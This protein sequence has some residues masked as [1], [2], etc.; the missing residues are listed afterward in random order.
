MTTRYVLH[1]LFHLV[2]LSRALS[3]LRSLLQQPPSPRPLP[4]EPRV[5]P[6]APSGRRHPLPHTPPPPVDQAVPSSPPLHRSFQQED[7]YL[8]SAHFLRALLRS[9]RAPPALLPALAHLNRLLQTF[10]LPPAMLLLLDEGVSLRVQSAV[11]DLLRAELLLFRV[12]SSQSSGEIGT[13]RDAAGASAVAVAVAAG[14]L[15]RDGASAPAGAAAS[16]DAAGVA[17]D[18]DHGGGRFTCG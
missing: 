8:N 15:G 17:A 13:L 14:S 16:L 12:V 1:S 18:D 11:S 2:F 4:S 7:L 5:S 10:P 3:W 9:S 6:R